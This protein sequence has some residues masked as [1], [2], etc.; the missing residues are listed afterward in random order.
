[1]G[2]LLYVLAAAV[3]YLFL[4]FQASREA[5]SRALELQIRARE[6]ELAALRAQRDQELAEREL[7]LAR[8]IQ[9]RLLPPAEIEGTG[10]R[11]AARNLPAHFVAGDFFDVFPLADGMLCLAVAD[12]AGKGMGASLIMASVKAV[13]PLIAAQHTV[14][15]TLCELNRK[16]AADLAE[17]EFVALA[18]AR[19]DPRNGRL[20]L[21]NSGLPD[22]YLLRHGEPCRE[23]AV[24][25]PRYPLGIRPQV[26][27]QS[28]EVMLEPSDR[29]VL[30]TDGL[31]EARD[32]DGDP[33]GYERLV[34]LL[35]HENPSP[36]GWL[37][38]LLERLSEVT[39]PQLDDDV[40]A[41]VLQRL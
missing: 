25:G 16:L 15:G 35:D 24:Q 41:L 32:P 18:L 10:Y 39:R 36:A 5:E 19:F 33:L 1:V 26:D 17:R 23:I 11:L 13:L 31:P 37:D 38:E 7:E 30:I 40:T 8:S 6:A 12:V 29:L 14:V 3:H 4:A 20:E 21:A 34:G 27:Y 9:R 2:I 22:P 28:V